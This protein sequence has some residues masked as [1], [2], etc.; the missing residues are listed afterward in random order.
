MMFHSTPG[1]KA[2]TLPINFHNVIW[3]GGGRKKLKSGS[4]IL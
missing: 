1:G 3:E 2:R 4:G